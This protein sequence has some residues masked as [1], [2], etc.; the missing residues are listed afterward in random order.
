VFLPE[1]SFCQINIRPQELLILENTSQGQCKSCSQ[2][3][4][5]P[6]LPDVLRKIKFESIESVARGKVIY[7]VTKGMNRNLLYVYYSL[8]E[9]ALQESQQKVKNQSKFSKIIKETKNADRIE[10]NEEEVELIRKRLFCKPLN[11]KSIQVISGLTWKQTDLNV[12][13]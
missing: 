9:Q 10:E 5:C 12:S 4:F 8:E 11:P 7:Y 13:F 6:L 2:V 3:D 1:R